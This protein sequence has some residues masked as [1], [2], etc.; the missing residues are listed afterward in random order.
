MFAA[1]PV[2]FELFAECNRSAGIMGV[3]STWVAFINN[4]LFPTMLLPLLLDKAE[5][6]IACSMF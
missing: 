6:S 1:R 4:E 5:S 2:D 3:P